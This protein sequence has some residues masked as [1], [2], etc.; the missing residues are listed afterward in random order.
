VW[1]LPPDARILNL[2]PLSDDDLV[3]IAAGT[4]VCLLASILFAVI[5][6]AVGAMF[7]TK[8]PT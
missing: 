5:A 3:G 1:P 4:L 8:G 6:H 2:S 7:Q